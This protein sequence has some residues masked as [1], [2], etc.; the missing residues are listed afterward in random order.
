MG[1]KLGKDKKLLLIL[2]FS[3][4]IVGAVIFSN[5]ISFLKVQDII[6]EQLQKAQRTE[7]EHATGR[8][9]NHILETKDQLVT[10]SKF[11]EITSLDLSNCANETDIIQQKFEGKIESLLLAD[12][13]GNIIGCSST[14][15]ANFV[16]LNIKNK[17]YFSVPKETRE[18]HITQITL[19][20][21]V[22]QIILS[23]PL[24]QSNSYTPYPNFM[25]EFRGVLLTILD[26]NHLYNLYLHPVIH[27][28]KNFFILYNIKTGETL[29]KSPE[30]KEYSLLKSLL[31]DSHLNGIY[32]FDTM[33]ETIIT[34]SEMV[35]G[36]QR[37]RLVILTPLSN[38]S[39]DLASVQFRHL[40][41]MFFILAVAAVTIYFFITLSYSHHKVQAQLEEAHVTLKS[42]G[43]QI[44][45]EKDKYHDADVTLSAGKLY[46]IKEDEENHAHELFISTLNSGYAGLGIVRTNPDLLKRKYNLENTS[47]IWLTKT[48][49]KGFLT[50]TNIDT[51]FTLISQFVKESTKSVVLIDRLDYLITEH[52]FEKVIKKIYLLNDLV[53]HHECII[54]LALDPE[55]LSPQQLKNLESESVDIYG[56]S[57]KQKVVLDELER[58]ILNFINEKNIINQLISYKDITSTFNITKPTT[59]ARISKLQRMGMLKVDQQGRFKS[60]KLTSVARKFII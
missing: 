53:Q 20:G 38:A 19:Q 23:V 52:E 41:S 50:E 42:F 6:T 15:F 48:K 56:T 4:I 8:I 16:G 28:G 9:E 32:P 34:S 49:T 13:E 51:L 3:L 21:S 2:L 33:G 5:Y 44:N 57:L 22:P 58:G 25:G 30:L 14:R 29:M 24:F 1:E 39:V 27:S 11:P 31:P 45:T 59:R 47:F 26:M 60:L 18:P 17:D 46:L 35:L 10:L 36:T 43:I 7:T 12:D 55:L 40:M 54:L 37:L